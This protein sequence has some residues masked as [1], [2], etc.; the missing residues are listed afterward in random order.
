MP[1]D[2]RGTWLSMFLDL[3]VEKEQG[4]ID[5]RAPDPLSE[6][7]DDFIR[8]TRAIRRRA[9]EDDC[10]VTVEG[11]VNQKRLMARRAP[12]ENNASGRSGDLKLLL[13]SS[14]RNGASAFISD[15]L[16]YGYPNL[17]AYSNLPVY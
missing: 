16:S 14:A 1:R 4:E 15:S 8:C 6:R 10:R 3:C 11:V 13:R 9:C 12:E 17:P 5:P 7:A 2:G